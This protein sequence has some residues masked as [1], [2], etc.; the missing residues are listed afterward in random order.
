MRALFAEFV[1]TFALL[2]AILF[3][4]SWLWIGAALALVVYA[5][6]GI[7]GGH[8]NPAV[9]FAMY[10]KGAISMN[11]FFMYSLVQ[12]AGAFAA[13]YTYRALA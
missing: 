6:G 9:S 10:M 11:E 4:G 1:G 13:L 5:I 12:L 8:V 7:S 3:T 2:S